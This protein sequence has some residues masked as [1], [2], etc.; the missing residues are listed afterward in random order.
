YDSSLD[1]RD[2]TPTDY[3]TASS[4]PP[5]PGAISPLPLSCPA[6]RR[7]S[8]GAPGLPSARPCLVA[9][10]LPRVGSSP[11]SPPAAAARPRRIS[12]GPAALRRAGIAC[13]SF[14]SRRGPPFRGSPGIRGEWARLPRTRRVA[15]ATSYAEPANRIVVGYPSGGSPA[16]RPLI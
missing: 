3:A 16:V 7:V 11:R 10:S 5:A 2:D 14:S 1:G 12:S 15:A 9:Q 8:L 6:L 13:R 4:P